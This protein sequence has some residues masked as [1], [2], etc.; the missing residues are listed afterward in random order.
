MTH[1]RRAFDRLA[2]AAFGLLLLFTLAGQPA[3]AEAPA[4]VGRTTL[5]MVDDVNCGYCRKWDREV[6]GAY[7]KSAEGKFAP[8]TRLRRGHPS[9]AGINSLAYTPTFVL[10]V[11]GREVGRIIGYPGADFFWAELDQLMRRGGVSPDAIPTEQ[12]ADL[13]DRRVRIENTIQ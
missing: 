9:L 1:A 7:P 11:G 3:R 12:R 10:F 8:L 13:G 5:L 4:F 2:A 6:G